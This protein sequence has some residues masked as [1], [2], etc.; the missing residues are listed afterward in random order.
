MLIFHL[1]NSL[2]VGGTENFL[3]SLI[4]ND[5]K[6]KHIIFCLFKNGQFFPNFKK[7]KNCEVIS[8]KYFFFFKKISFIKKNLK[9][10]KLNNFNI[11]INSWMYKSH[12]FALI[13]KIFYNFYFIMHI[14]HSGITN[15]HKFL[16]ILPIKI[17]K[18]ISYYA[19]KI[20]YNSFASKIEHEKVG[21][22]SLHSE[23]IQNG[24]KNQ[25]QRIKINKTNNNKIVIGMLSRT[26]FIKDQLTLLKAFRNL[27]KI[28][29][30]LELVLQGK[31]VIADKDIN[32]FIKE[33][34][35]KNVN[36]FENQ[37]KS[38]FFS[39]I[40]IHV[41]SSFGES[42]PNVVVEAIIEK[43]VSLSSDVGDIK[44]ILSSDCIFK[45][46]NSKSLEIKL[47]TKIN[48]IIKDNFS[49][50]LYLEKLKKKILRKFNISSVVKK[51]NEIWY[52]NY[53]NLN[54]LLIVPSLRGGGAEGNFA[55]LSEE[56][57]KK[58]INTTLVVL[59]NN[60][61]SKFKIN[62]KVRLNYL[63]TKRSIFASY[64]ILKLF[65]SDYNIIISTIV[66]CNIICILCK[67]LSF[68]R[69]KL[70]VRET[71]TPSEYFRFSKGLKSFLLVKLRKFYKFS[72]LVICN[73]NGVLNDLN[74]NF[75]IEK[76][77]LFLLPNSLNFE[78]IQIFLNKK[79]NK[80]NNP[81][82]LYAGSFTAQKNLPMLIK[83]FKI[84]SEKNKNFKLFLIGDGEKREIKEMIKKYNL[85]K[86]IIIKKFTLKIFNYIRE[87]HSVL[88][89]SNWEGMP[90]VILQALH[91]KKNVI[92]TDCNFG[93][94]ELKNFGYDLT[95]CKVND[96]KNFARNLLL[97]SLKKKNLKDIVLVNRKFVEL[98]KN[99]LNELIN[100]K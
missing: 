85:Q 28:Y 99:K 68:G 38:N 100:E 98:Y 6:N 83:S 26:N 17:C 69:I 64:Q 36:L 73:S 88:L 22:N 58:N 80:K 7:L 93:P 16:N 70:Y 11:C 29:P 35:L 40:D 66:Q 9:K 34:D 46:N 30:S 78:E 79:N 44:Y 15:K 65:Y 10:H 21:Y 95:L 5:K 62:K 49:T 3:Y 76:K 90:N 60:E 57:I 4:S 50:K 54:Y 45:K 96:H 48:E 25:K 32:K 19:N 97:S 41:L 84:F 47:L 63:N 42:F 67:I 72:D 39:K 1:I 53:H 59:G 33:N 75:G 24:F 74:K 20:I 91:L 56:F 13:L 71:N 89:T 27:Q 14:R 23:V 12:F 61:S 81:F 94:K 92:C 82:F 86:R 18:H 51:I 8:L 52:K 55:N 31:G 2:D 37:S 87:C 77:K 43:K